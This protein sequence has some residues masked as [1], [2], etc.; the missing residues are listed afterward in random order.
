MVYVYMIYTYLNDIDK[1]SMITYLMII[2]VVVFV[3]TKINITVVH[4]FAIG[5]ALLIGYYLNDKRVT[6]M[7]DYNEKL[8]YKLNTLIPRPKNF[9]MDP[10]VINFFFNIREMKDYNQQAYNAAMRFTD[11]LLQIV[12]DVDTGIYWCKYN[13][14][15]AYQKYQSAMN[16]LHSL[17]YDT[18]STTVTLKKY[19]DALEKFQLILRRHIDHIVA[20]C[21]KQYATHELNVDT[22]FIDATGGPQPDDTHDPDYNVHYNAY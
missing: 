16:S 7:E 17:I 19:Q 4:I 9:Q 8:D 22:M 21:N 1:V 18:P 2:V 11:E 20:K 15:V 12:S 3:A 6:L 13:Y 14:D 5:C 10:D